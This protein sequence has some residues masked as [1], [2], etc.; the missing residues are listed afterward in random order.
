MNWIVGTLLSLC[1]VWR[2]SCQ[3]D[4]TDSHS[5]MRLMWMTPIQTAPLLSE[6]QNHAILTGIKEDSLKYY[7]SFLSSNHNKDRDATISDTFYIS[8]QKAYLNYRKCLEQQDKNKVSCTHYLP[9][10]IASTIVPLILQEI[11]TF[12]KN[13]FIEDLSLAEVQRLQSLTLAQQSL[14]LWIGIHNNGSYHENH[15][16]EDS[17]VSGVFYVSVPSSG[18]GQLVFQDPRGAFPPFGKTLRINPTPGKIVLFPGWLVHGVSPTTS[19][20]PRISISFNFDGKWS[21]T[22]DL[23]QA[24]FLE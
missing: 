6:V 9:E 20:E 16:H 8:Q 15:H 12:Y 3:D 4:P 13:C 17:V 24:Y 2:A 5:A 21:T 10:S 22:S 1:H 23:N 11:K 18:A 7:Q 14:F 19:V